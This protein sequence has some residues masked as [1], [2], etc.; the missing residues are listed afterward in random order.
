M[1]RQLPRLLMKPMYMICDNIDVTDMLEY[2]NN[3]S[4][5]SNP[6]PL[7]RVFKKSKIIILKNKNINIY[8]NH[9]AIRNFIDSFISENGG[10]ITSMI[11]TKLNAG[12]N[13]EPHIDGVAKDA[14]RQHLKDFTDSYKNLDRYHLV[15]DGTYE[16]TVENNKNIFSKGELWWFNNKKMHSALC[17]TDKITLI[18][19]HDPKK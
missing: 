16:Y 14:E 4:I 5:W 15:L 13:I 10:E 18:F 7:R 9:I 2:I 19:D 17:I 8:Y 11:L 3:N 6:H 1:F 12:D